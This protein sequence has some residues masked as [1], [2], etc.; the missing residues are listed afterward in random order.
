MQS[1]KRNANQLFK[2]LTHKHW[3]PIFSLEDT[4]SAEGQK[5]A[6]KEGSNREQKGKI[7]GDLRSTVLYQQHTKSYGEKHMALTS[8]CLNCA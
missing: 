6:D 8:S 2:E 4:D 1:G 5:Q 3:K 7:S